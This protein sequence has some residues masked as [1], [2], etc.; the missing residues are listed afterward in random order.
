M[1][2]FELVLLK[3]P[4]PLENGNT[5]PGMVPDYNKTEDDICC[6]GMVDIFTNADEKSIRSSIQEVLVNRIP[7]IHHDDFDFVKVKGKKIITPVFK[8][9]QEIGY[10]QL[11]AL[12][13]QGSLYVRLNNDQKFADDIKNESDDE[14]KEIK[15]VVT[16]S[17]AAK[18]ILTA[19]SSNVI[20]TTNMP[21]ESSD[22]I[23]QLQLI[24]P[25]H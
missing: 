24:F 25:N 2:T 4:E 22:N 18:V 9:G 20:T 15:G 5:P 6:S 14:V 17:L 16:T 8:K 23:S 7:D 13:G 19:S 3:S 21:Q 10:Q 11:K 1:K 12:S